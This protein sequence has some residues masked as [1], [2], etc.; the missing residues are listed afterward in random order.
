[1]NDIE[2]A[3]AQISDIRAHLAAS[4]RFRGY[5]P[6]VL[7]GIAAICVLVT[8]LQTFWP[9]RLAANDVQQVV[10]WGA[11][12]ILSNLAML[13]EAFTR[14]RWE[15]GGMAPAM[16]HSTLRMHLPFAGVAVIIAVG[17]CRFA[18]AA[19][20]IVP[21]IWQLL[22]ALT[23]FVSHAF[24]PRRIV[25]AGLWYGACGTIVIAVAGSQGHFDPWL[26]GGPMTI[27]HLLLAWLL[28]QAEGDSRDV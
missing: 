19:A 7:V 17:I 4:T 20:W 23:A 21:G 11:V 9:D 8:L 10:V 22:I 14:A 1:M 16:L 3:I 2:R 6:E 13:A 28:R 25:W 26:M 24:L 18:P 15:H 12:L 5:A 27:G